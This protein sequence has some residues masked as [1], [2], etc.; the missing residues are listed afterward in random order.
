MSISLNLIETDE[1][2]DVRRSMDLNSANLG[3]DH[4]S[5]VA[6]KNCRMGNVAL[7][8]AQIVERAVACAPYFGTFH[9]RERNE[10]AMRNVH[11]LLGQMSG[12]KQALTLF[13]A[14]NLTTS[15]G[16]TAPEAFDGAP[17][18]CPARLDGAGL[19]FR[20]GNPLGWP[21]KPCVAWPPC[22]RVAAERLL[23][24]ACGSAEPGILL[25]VENK[26]PSM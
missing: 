26:V 15:E 17:T 9:P 18:P 3:H 1:K 24:G 25:I 10:L 7:V 16:F 12:L 22:C 20:T 8:L 2:P 5:V 11:D 4:T 23:P 13:S 14:P 19:P 21:L 6:L